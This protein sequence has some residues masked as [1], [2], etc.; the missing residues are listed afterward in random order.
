MDVSTSIALMKEQRGQGG[1]ASSTAPLDRLIF[2]EGDLSKVPVVPHA[3][4]VRRLLHA[5]SR[6]LHGRVPQNATEKDF[7][8]H[9]ETLRPRDLA[10]EAIRVKPLRQTPRVVTNFGNES[11][12]AADE[13]ERELRHV[14][15]QM[16]R[17]Q[18]G[19]RI[20]AGGAC[21][22]KAEEEGQGGSGINSSGSGP[23]QHSSGSGPSQ[24][25]STVPES[26]GL[27]AGMSSAGTIAKLLAQ[28]PD[29]PLTSSP[30][31]AHHFTSGGSR[32]QLRKETRRAVNREK[33]REANLDLRKQQLVE[34][35]MDLL[36]RLSAEQQTTAEADHA[37]L[38]S[39]SAGRP[40]ADER[41]TVPKELAPEGRG[42]KA[43]RQRAFSPSFTPG[44]GDLHLVADTPPIPAVTESG[45]GTGSGTGTGTSAAKS[46]N[47]SGQ[48]AFF[49]STAARVGVAAVGALAVLVAAG[50]T[51]SAATKR[52]R[53]AKRASR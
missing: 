19:G 53:M 49:D 36:Q 30:A 6:M 33:A 42:A 50:A 24:H 15:T 38:A 34:R 39:M 3:L 51:I 10:Q 35:N 16:A 41:L 7:I 47:T 25:P 12:L 9:G 18:G 14:R 8:R 46:G 52:R 40:A 28:R 2:Q 4:A 43:D 45:S 27:R 20:T 44:K 23:S 31:P 13:L 17:Q 11:S 32:A 26:E 21:G 1:S 22:P 29:A 37:L 5:D 48:A